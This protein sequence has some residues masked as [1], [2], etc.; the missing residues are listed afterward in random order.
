MAVPSLAISSCHDVCVPEYRTAGLSET[1]LLRLK[2]RYWCPLCV[3]STLVLCLRLRAAQRYGIGAYT[4]DTH[5]WLERSDINPDCSGC[6]RSTHQ[7][8][9][10]CNRALLQNGTPLTKY[11]CWNAASKSVLELLWMALYTKTPGVLVV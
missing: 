4:T 3:L 9:V 10:P 1:F 5:N 2:L 8:R 7:F 11:K 6:W